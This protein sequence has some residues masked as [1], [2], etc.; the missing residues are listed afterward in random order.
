MTMSMAFT[1]RLSR[2]ILALTEL[3]RIRTP[4]SESPPG[5]ARDLKVW[6]IRG[7]GHGHRP[8]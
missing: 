5:R 6:S 7:P 3:S 8:R 1:S 2:W 4:E